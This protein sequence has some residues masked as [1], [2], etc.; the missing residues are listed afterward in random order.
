MSDIQSWTYEEKKSFLIALRAY[1]DSDLFKLQSI[2]PNKGI[3]E[4]RKIIDHYKNKA[5]LKWLNDENRKNDEIRNWLDI[6]EK[7]N[8]KQVGPIHDIIPRVLKYIALFE[9]KSKNSDIKMRE[10]YL[11]LSEISKIGYGSKPKELPE[12]ARYLVYKCLHQLAQNLQNQDIEETKLF[13]K[14]LE[15]FDDLV[16]FRK[17]AS[18]NSLH[19]PDYLLQVN[20]SD[21]VEDN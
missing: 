13:L 20:K 10:V 4:I 8:S 18:V 11:Y 5:Q 16:Q 2:L 7:I 21:F 14:G 19:V 6:L 9:N 17:E 1:G 12:R 15:K 3:T